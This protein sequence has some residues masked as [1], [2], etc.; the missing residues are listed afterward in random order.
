MKYVDIADF[1][2]QCLE[3][4]DE[5]ELTGVTIVVT[6]N[7]RPLAHVKPFVEDRVGERRPAADAPAP[8]APPHP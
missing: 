5:V 2:P 1:E 8:N 4:M 3:Y 6:Q 7:G